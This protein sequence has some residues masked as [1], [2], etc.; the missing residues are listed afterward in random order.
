MEVEDTIKRIA[1]HKGVEGIIICN[2]DGVALKSTLAPAL[3]AKYAGLLSQLVVKARGVVRTIDA[4]VSVCSQSGVSSPDRRQLQT[5]SKCALAPAALQ[6]D[7]VFLRV[8][9]K[10][11]EIMIAPD[12]EYLLVVIQNPAAADEVSA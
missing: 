1:S 3:T 10:K 7:L 9:S 11:H 4:E 8:R 5:P 6:N 12:R 2:Y